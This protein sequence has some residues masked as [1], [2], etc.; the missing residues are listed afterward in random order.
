MV[1]RYHVT[2][3]LLRLTHKSPRLCLTL[4]V[5][6]NTCCPGIH[7]QLTVIRVAAIVPLTSVPVKTPLMS[8]VLKTKLPL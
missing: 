7:A 3:F 1:N 4:G 6:C 2:G 5:R 8:Y